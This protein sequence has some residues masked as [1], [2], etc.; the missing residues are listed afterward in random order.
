MIL[1]T[2]SDLAQQ[3]RARRRELGLTQE[4]LAALANLHRT[5]ISLFESGRRAIRFDVALRILNTLGMDLDLLTR[6]G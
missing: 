1:R 6:G 2:T 3:V 5:Y 4:D